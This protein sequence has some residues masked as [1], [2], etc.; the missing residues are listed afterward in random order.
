MLNLSDY[1]NNFNL[2]SI[3]PRVWVKMI[4][5]DY[6]F[7]G[8]GPTLGRKAVVIR[9]KFHQLNVFVFASD[10]FIIS[11]WHRHRK[12]PFRYRNLC[13]RSFSYFPFSRVLC[14]QQVKA[15]YM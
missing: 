15:K 12:D 5:K 3:N 7:T 10:F 1:L 14:E 8:I 9:N 11:S 6:H 4:N 13:F 2:G